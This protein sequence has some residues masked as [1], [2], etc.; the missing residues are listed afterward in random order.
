[1]SKRIKS[2]R[3]LWPYF[4]IGAVALL[5]HGLLLLNDGTYWDG[6]LLKSYLDEGNWGELHKWATEAGLPGMD[7]FYWGLKLTRLFAFYKIIA[8]LLILFS[9]ILVYRVI[10]QFNW[11]NRCEALGVALLSLVYPAYQTTVELSTFRYQFFYCLFLLAALLLVHAER[12]TASAKSGLLLR[13]P[14]LILFFASFSLNSLL[15]FYFSFLLL[16]FLNIRQTKALSWSDIARTQVLRRMDLL[17]L[18]MLYWAI[19]KIFFPTHG[20]YAGYNSLNLDPAAMLSHFGGFMQTAIY[21]QVDASL[22][23]LIGQP[24]A[25]ALFLACVYWAYSRFQDSAS[26]PLLTHHQVE[27][28]SHQS[29]WFFA[30]GIVLLI[31]GIFPYAAVGVSPS[32]SGWNTRHALLVGLPMALLIVAALRPL[33]IGGLYVPH[34]GV[35]RKL[36][37]ILIGSSLVAAFALST[38]SFY[39]GWQARAVKDRAIMVDLADAPV[40]K[41]F[42]VFWIDDQYPAGGERIYRF[43]EWSSMFK[44]IWGGESRIGFQLQGY[45]QASLFGLK[46]IYNKSNNLSEFD[47]SG[48]QVG[49]TITRGVLQYSQDELVWQYFIHRFFKQAQMVNF[50]HGVV[51]LDVQI[52]QSTDERCKVNLP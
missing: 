38:V 16:L 33:W 51:H 18:P 17:L 46:Q 3:H 41:K 4:F 23:K 11:L 43:Y 50:L 5:S 24:L 9:A 40:L 27:Q 14:S 44:Q 37:S 22:T 35:D 1:M 8:F 25:W 34:A 39:V 47:P 30:F 20:A 13:L 49:L 32:I 36:I 48:C 19:K 7:Y 45:N 6:W 31:S 15:V 52:P 42:S 2:V 28:K 26:R 10:S 29:K 12:T 21:G